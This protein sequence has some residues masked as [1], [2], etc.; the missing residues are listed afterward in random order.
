[1][2]QAEHIDLNLFANAHH[3]PGMP[4]APPTQLRNMDETISPS[5]VHKG[6]KTAEAADRP[7]AHLSLTQ[8]IKQFL[9]RLLSPILLGCRRRQDQ[10]ALA[11]V[12][13][14]NFDRQF[15]TNHS[16]QPGQS[17]LLAQTVWKAWDLRSRNKA[18][19][20]FHGDHQ[21]A[22][23][24]ADDFSFPDLS[25]ISQFLRVHPC[26]LLAGHIQRDQQVSFLVLRTQDVHRDFAAHSQFSQ[27]LFSH[28]LH[29]RIGNNAISLG[30]NVS[31]DLLLADGKDN[32]R[33]DFAPSGSL[34]V[35]VLNWNPTH[36]GLIVLCL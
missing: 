32:A 34:I 19:D 22:L 24:I 25:R 2:I 27:C 29:I 12:D 5:Q 4:D 13:L 18:S 36:F 1:M 31:N 33:A 30:P 16:G 26:L 15:L 21:P 9:A 10:A 35:P 23:V 6:T 3:L 20:L 17:L 7:R 8:I 28:A 11:P 14:D